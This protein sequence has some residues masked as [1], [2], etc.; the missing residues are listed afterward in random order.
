YF[1]G[2]IL[3]GI[4]IFL[5]FIASKITKYSKW[6]LLYFLISMYLNLYAIQFIA[7][8][9]SLTI[10]YGQENSIMIFLAAI[11][12]ISFYPF[13]PLITRLKSKDKILSILIYIST[14]PVLGANI[15]YPLIFYPQT[16]EEIDAGE[17]KYYIT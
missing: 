2:L 10:D 7:Y 1:G 4:Y 8:S 17:Y 15:A 13:Y 5:A 14:L 11:V 3:F 6:T 12:I 16:I 9:I